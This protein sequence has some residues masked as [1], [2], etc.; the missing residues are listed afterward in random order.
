MF[1]EAL[2]RVKSI[3][4]RHCGKTYTPAGITRLIR[5]QFCDPRL[6]FR[7]TKN[8]RV[9]KGNWWI[10]GQYDM[11]DDQEDR[12]CI[13]INLTFNPRQ[14]QMRIDSFDWDNLAFHVADVVT[15]EYLHQYYVR[16]RG[17]RFGLGYRRQPMD[18]GYNDNMKNYLGCED[19]IL[20]YGFSAAAEMLVYGRSFDQTKVARMYRRHF[21]QDQKVVIQ[22]QKQTL[23][24]IK[25]WEQSNEQT[26]PGRRILNR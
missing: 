1:F 11:I 26:S 12:A 3:A 9:E 6:R 25:R 13:H 16:R 20:A 5:S 8:S 2:R 23:K 14:R 7:T 17:Y 22:L 4:H 24:Y 10:G 15:H 21:K 18:R 19:E